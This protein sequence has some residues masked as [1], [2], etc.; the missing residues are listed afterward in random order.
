MTKHF[1]PVAPLSVHRQLERRG[2]LGPYNLLIASEILK[3]ME[4]YGHFW[5]RVLR[6]EG[7]ELFVDNGV[8][9]LGYAL[10]I[11]HLADAVAQVVA[12]T[13]ILPDTI[14]DMRMTVK[15]V[16]NAAD[17]WRASGVAGVKM[18]GVVQGTTVAECVD[19]ATAHAKAGVDMLAI[20]RG[21]TKNL[22]SRSLV[23]QIISEEH[24]NKPLHLLGFSENI[25]DDIFTA[26]TT[27]TVLG[28][29]A[30]TPVWLGMAARRGLFT[31]RP[32][33]SADFGP[34]PAWFWE[35]GP[36]EGDSL[37]DIIHN[38]TKVRQWLSVSEAKTDL[39]QPAAPI[40]RI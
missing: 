4:G 20:P 8:I 34:R 12:T 36:Q 31:A 37:Q 15:Q 30:A 5:T 16:H 13:I 9:E 1:A 29:D 22:G 21:L 39:D 23:A 2:A 38:V 32:P 35:A 14:D 7:F 27:P 24:P 3:D 10:P 25:E 26:A 19:C 40:A 18:L 11:V 17:Q 6:E 33:K 28:I